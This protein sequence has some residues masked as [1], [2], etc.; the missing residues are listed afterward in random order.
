MMEIYLKN[1]LWFVLIIF[2]GT[3]IFAVVQ[4]I[5][6]LLDIRNTAKD[7]KKMLKDIEIRVRAL[8]SLLD[9]V[10]MVFGGIEEAKRKVMDRTLSASNLS[11]YAAGLKKGVKVLFGGEK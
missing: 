3:L 4:I 11:A 2:V 6:I 9:V 5:L 7:A 10:S 1:I 8:T